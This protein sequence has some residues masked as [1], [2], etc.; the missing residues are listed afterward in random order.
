MAVRLINIILALAVLFSSTGFTVNKHYCQGELKDLALFVHAQSC[1]KKNMHQSCS[2]DKDSCTGHD[3]EKDNNCCDDD[4]DYH[5]LDQ[6]QQIESFQLEL[7]KNPVLLS[8]IFV[9]LNIELPS[10]DA[11]TLHQTTYQPPIVCEDI[12]VLLQTFLL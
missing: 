11:N 12:P 9:I 6:N 8:T 7:L 5:K 4:T 2:T 10:V 3:H 1:H